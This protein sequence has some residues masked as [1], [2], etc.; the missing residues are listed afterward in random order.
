MTLNEMKKCF[1][2]AND[3]YCQFENVENKLSK[4]A[5]LHAFI[6]L[7]RLDDGSSEYYDDI[8]VSSHHD[9][10]CLGVDAQIVAKHITKEQIVDLVRCGVRFSDDAFMMFT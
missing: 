2:D 4:R 6:I 1:D 5:D 10:I 9:E 3:Q 8:V 7:D